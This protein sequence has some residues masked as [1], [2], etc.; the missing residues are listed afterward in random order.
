[1]SQENFER[2]CTDFVVMVGLLGSFAVYVL[3]RE[4]WEQVSGTINCEQKC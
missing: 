2:V 4:L 1:M 3:L